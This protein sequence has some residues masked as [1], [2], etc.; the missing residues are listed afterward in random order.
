MFDLE[1]AISEW[2]QAMRRSPSI[3]D[4]DLAELERYLRDKV[5][6]L[7]SQGSGPEEAF[8]AAEEEFRRAGTLDAAYGHVRAARPAGRF[9]WRPQRFSPGLLMSYVRIGLRNLLKY[10]GYSFINIAGLAIGLACCIL[11]FVYI[12]TELSF[13]RYHEYSQHIYRLGT[14][15][16]FQENSIIAAVSNTPAGPA[17]VE[18]FP[19]ILG[20]VRF[21]PTS[22]RTVVTY[23]DRQYYEGGI[24]Y[25]DGSVF[26]VF[27]FPMIKGD[28]KTA[29]K[30]PY[31][32]VITESIAAKYFGPEGPLGKTVRLENQQDLT[33]TGVIKNVPRNSHFT[34]NMLVSFETLYAQNRRAQERWLGFPDYTYLLLAEKAKSEDLESK[35]PAFVESHM[36]E[37]LKAVNGKLSYFLQP[38]TRIHLYSRLEHEISG[39]SNILYVYIFAAIAF[40][41]LL[42]ACINFINL[43]TARSASRAKEIGIRKMCGAGR[44]DLIR[45][46]LAEIFSQVLISF[47][48]AL[49]LAELAFSLLGS[50]SGIDLRIGASRLQWLIP[51]LIVLLLF[52]GVAAGSYP[53][54]LLSSY[55]PAKV[56]K[57]DLKDGS[58]GSRF[59]GALVVF[60]FTISISLIIGTAIVMIQLHFMKT[61]DPGFSKEN[62]I[63]V[64]IMPQKLQQA[65]P[66][67]KERLGQVPGVLRVAATST[68]PGTEPNIGGFIPEGFRDDQTQIM[69]IMNVNSDFIPTMGITIVSGRNFSPEFGADGQAKVLINQTAARKFGWSD[70]VGRTIRAYSNVS[71]KWEPQTVIGVVKDFHISSFYRT[72]APLYISNS[73]QGLGGLV[74]KIRRENREGTLGTLQNIWRD[75]DP[76]RP[77]DYFFLEDY[78]DGQYKSEERLR[79]IMGSFAVFSIVI[80]CLGLFGM[81]SCS[82]ARR[83]KEIG[84][85]KILGAS[86]AEIALMLAKESAKRVLLANVIAWPVAYFAM[87]SWLRHFAYRSRIGPWIFVFSAILS[88]FIAVMTVSYQAIR[89]AVADPVESLRYE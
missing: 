45:Q 89:A 2:K 27:T 23:G 11:I 62:T 67:I 84:I 25:A 55:R 86:A 36:A 4:G 1:K 51:S 12:L 61:R 88:L 14:K 60:Q 30:A 5:D 87:N 47:F 63:I 82:V 18:D 54:F 85:R 15:A 49:G 57:G 40:F 17:L 70:A 69:A 9:P 44:K 7:I 68:V 41:I 10:K 43:S 53:A 78:F 39:M 77:F 8:R 33:V 22:P 79:G 16:I 34:F 48:I 50:I 24:F 81:T 46:F 59:R 66:V 37:E 64:R 6:D 3:E 76:D 21:R 56:L 31:S 28:P 83:T 19:D 52:V 71:R 29:L 42:L 13:D 80:G 20:A 74:I 32:L 75:I 72:I 58:A 65:Y 38:L 35:L 73:P 26:E